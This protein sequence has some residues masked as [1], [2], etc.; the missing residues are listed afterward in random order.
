VSYRRRQFVV[1]GESA[2]VEVVAGWLAD[3]EE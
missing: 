2:L 1:D 3:D